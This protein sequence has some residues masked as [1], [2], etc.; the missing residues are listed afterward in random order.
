MEIQKTGGDEG[1]A[2]WWG[3]RVVGPARCKLLP[4]AKA[5]PSGTLLYWLHLGAPM[6]RNQGGMAQ[7]LPGDG[8]R[9]PWGAHPVVA[10]PGPG[11]I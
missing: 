8:P 1:S 11:R 7:P 3:E 9:R 2:G 4:A 5:R 6:G 10:A